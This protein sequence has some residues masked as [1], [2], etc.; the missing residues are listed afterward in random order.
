M[1]EQAHH[2][3]WLTEVL[4][5]VREAEG[6]RVATDP[7]VRDRLHYGRSVCEQVLRQNPQSQLAIQVRTQID[8]LL[9]CVPASSAPAS[10]ERTIT[11]A[12]AQSMDAIIMGV[13]KGMDRLHSL[14]EER[15]QSDTGYVPG[16]MSVPFS[17]V[18]H[19]RSN[20]YKNFPKTWL[21]MHEGRSSSS[22]RIGHGQFGYDLVPERFAQERNDVFG[23]YD[24]RHNIIR[25]P[26]GFDPSCLFDLV[27][28]YHELCHVAQNH[29]LRQRMGDDEYVR[30]YGCGEKRVLLPMEIEAYALQFEMMDRVLGGWL[31]SGAAD[32]NSPQRLDAL[33]TQMNGKE[34][35]RWLAGNMLDGMR[36]FFPHGWRDDRSP[37]ASSAFSRSVQRSYSNEGRLYTLDAQGLP[38]PL[39]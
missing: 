4:Q 16:G 39:M 27:L 17:L 34:K 9:S 22:Y 32:G 3:Q 7:S 36:A 21:D 5:Q 8:R 25:M 23:Q 29:S 26:E 18:D 1:S 28:L 38:V 12:E 15:M 33:M 10:G 35:H 14:L 19:N 24:A 20:H 31:R 2:L 30:F 6:E 11:H 37:P 13:E